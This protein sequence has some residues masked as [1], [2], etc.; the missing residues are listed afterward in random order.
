VKF[1]GL[2]SA[3]LKSGLNSIFSYVVPMFLN[4]KIKSLF[5]FSI[6]LALCLFY[7]KVYF[8]LIVLSIL[9]IFIFFYFY[10]NLNKFKSFVW[11]EVLSFSLSLI[12]GFFYVFCLYD[13]NNSGPQDSLNLADLIYEISSPR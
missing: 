8:M 12:V 5:L 11:L 3:T 4:S 1:F 7:N 6:F 9:F 13:N 10:E 2:T